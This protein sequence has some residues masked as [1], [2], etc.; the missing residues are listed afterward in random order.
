MRP[1][2]TITQRVGVCDRREWTDNLS[3]SCPFKKSKKHTRDKITSLLGDERLTK[4][5]PRPDKKRKVRL[6]G[7]QCVQ[8]TSSLQDWEK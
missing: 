2:E 5:S 7:T 6:K 4:F 8:M 3:H 1:W